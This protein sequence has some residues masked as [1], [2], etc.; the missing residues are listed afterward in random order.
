MKRLRVSSGNVLANMIITVTSSS[1]QSILFF[2]PGPRS[3]FSR[4]PMVEWNKSDVEDYLDWLENHAPA[5]ELSGADVNKR[6]RKD[7]LEQIEE[8]DSIPLATP[9]R[10]NQKQPQA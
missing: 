2:S 10:S 6:F 3:T 5:E 9:T 7:I 1:L 8:T 4:C